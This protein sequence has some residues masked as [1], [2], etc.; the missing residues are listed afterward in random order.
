MR[1]VKYLNK[2]QFYYHYLIIIY[3]SVH[4]RHK[5]VVVY[6]EDNN[7]PPLGE[8]LN[9]PAI[10]SLERVWPIDKI[11]K[12][13]IKF[14]AKLQALGYEDILRKACQRLGAD[15]IVYAP[16]TG[17]WTFKVKFFLVL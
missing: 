14:P 12:N 4:F 11:T 3:F 7:K 15:F 17:L 6:P 5:E 10:V 13:P 16:E 1:L 8:G 2:L 9:C